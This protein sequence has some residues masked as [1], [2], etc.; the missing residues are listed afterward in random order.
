MAATVSFTAGLLAAVISDGDVSSITLASG[1]LTQSE[2]AA[3]SEEAASLGVRPLAG[4]R[5]IV[6]FS[7]TDVPGWL[8]T[9]IERANVGG[10]IGFADNVERKRQVRKLTAQLQEIDRPVEEPLLV[11][12]DQEGGLVKRL[13]GPPDMSAAEMGGA[14]ERASSRQGTATG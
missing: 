1:P 4:Q 11:M 6:G 12:V 7:D 2:L 13:P 14:G 8:R 10:V 5:V 3:A 9:A